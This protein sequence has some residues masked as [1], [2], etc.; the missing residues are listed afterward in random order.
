MVEVSLNMKAAGSSEMVVPIY[1]TAPRHISG[2]HNY[3]RQ[4]LG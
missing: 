4:W 2:D 1:Q 3:N